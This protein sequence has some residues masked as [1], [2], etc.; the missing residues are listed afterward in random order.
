MKTIFLALAISA[1]LA[2]APV[3]NAQFGGLLNRGGQQADAPD[4][5]AFVDSFV[6]SY[7]QV[8]TAQVHFAEALGLKDQVDLLKAEQQALGSGSIDTDRLKKISEVSTNAQRAI[9]ARQQ[10]QP[11]L[12]AQSKAAYGKGLVSLLEGVV[13]GRE[14]VQNAQ[15][16]GSSLGSN[17]M[18]LMGSARTASYVVKES[19]GYLKNLQQSARM[20]MQFG[21][22]NGIEAPSNATSLLDGM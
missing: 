11:A 20:A 1:A 19:P 8:L 6:T 18:S 17:P 3:A 21:K 12:D 15:A 22:D 13:T 10:E 5:E 2:A 16:V 9:D 4:A 7:T 14:V